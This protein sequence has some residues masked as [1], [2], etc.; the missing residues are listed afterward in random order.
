[1][2]LAVKVSDRGVTFPAKV[3]PRSARNAIVGLYGSSLKIK[4]TAP[5]A[6]GAANRMCVALLAD[7]LEVAESDIDIAAGITA[8]HKTIRIQRPSRS[9]GMAAAK[10]LRSLA[11]SSS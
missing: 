1:V 4:I 11:Q 2:T 3:I 6:G 8:R 7:V 9:A 10:R 5:P